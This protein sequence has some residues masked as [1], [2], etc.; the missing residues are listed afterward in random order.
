M[1]SQ[2]EAWWSYERVRG[3][4]A[5]AHSGRN[6]MASDNSTCSPRLESRTNP[7][8]ATGSGWMGAKK[9]VSE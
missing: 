1:L 4:K 5:Y 7:I 6:A 8:G 3:H 2:T 9:R